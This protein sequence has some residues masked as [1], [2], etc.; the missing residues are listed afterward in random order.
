MLIW[1]AMLKCQTHKILAKV[2][3]TCVMKMTERTMQK[4]VENQAEEPV[5][6]QVENQIRETSR[7]PLQSTIQQRR[8]F[9]DKKL[10]NYRQEKLKRKL[11]IDVQL[12]NC[13]HEE[14]EVVGRLD[15]S[16]G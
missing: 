15:G 8:N 14:L 2:K 10:D 13:A 9:L 16:N 4:S 6:S 5:E 11:P 12:L 3:V 1:V 7:E